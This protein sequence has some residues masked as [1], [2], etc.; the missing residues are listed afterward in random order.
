MRCP[1]RAAPRQPRGT[2]FLMNQYTI[3]RRTLLALCAF[4]FC[5]FV[6]GAAKRGGER[7]PPVPAS[8]PCGS[9]AFGARIPQA[10]FEIHFRAACR[11]GENGNLKTA[12]LRSG[13]GIPK[14]LRG[15]L[16]RVSLERKKAVA[17][18]FSVCN[19]LFGILRQSGRR[20]VKRRGPGSS[21]GKCR[22]HVPYA[23][24][25]PVLSVHVN[26]CGKASFPAGRHTDRRP[27]AKRRSTRTAPSASAKSPACPP[28]K[29]RRSRA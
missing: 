27:P 14:S 1:A 21:R 16:F 29:C 15:D 23:A 24:G 6:L 12:A 25:S 11:A 13:Q 18:V 26:A 20:A 4:V 7:Y 5:I 8:S 17:D 19:S 22:P 2:H 3:S 10:H 28:G 9:G